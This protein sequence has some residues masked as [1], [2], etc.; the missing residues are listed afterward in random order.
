M[1]PMLSN[2]AEAHR[3]PIREAALAL[4]QHDE[5]LAPS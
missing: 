1:L 5:Q 2:I 4:R 3:A